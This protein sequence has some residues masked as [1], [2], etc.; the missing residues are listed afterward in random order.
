[1]GRDQR[2]WNL[3]LTMPLFPT[4]P[5]PLSKTYAKVK[6]CAAWP[7]YAKAVR[8]AAEAEIARLTQLLSGSQPP[9]PPPPPPVVTHADEFFDALGH[10][11]WRENGVAFRDGVATPSAEVVRIAP[12]NG[13]ARQTNQQGNS[14]D[15][16]EAVK[17]WVRVEVAEPL[18]PPVV[19][20]PTV[21]PTAG[22]ALYGPH[23]M[24]C[25]QENEE[26]QAI[27]FAK[28]VGQTFMFA[29]SDPP[30][31]NAFHGEGDMYA[32]RMTKFLNAA[33]AEGMPVVPQMQ[34]SSPE[35]VADAFVRFLDHPAVL[36]HNGKPVFAFWNWKPPTDQAVALARQRYG[37]P[38]EV[39]TSFDWWELMQPLHDDQA[40]WDQLAAL[41]RDHP[42]ID[43][44]LNFVVGGNFVHSD[45]RKADK[46][47]QQNTNMVNACRAAGKTAIPGFAVRY[48]THIMSDADQA[49]V[50]DN[51]VQLKPEFVT[52]TSANDWGES[53]INREE[54]RHFHALIQ[55]RLAPLLT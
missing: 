8:T 17:Q 29:F 20:P 1:M 21:P 22:R 2:R 48:Q 44:V 13:V 5:P 3:G 4:E 16:S 30:F 35:A 55:S 37:K 9:P 31:S 49:R 41:F 45:P 7:T 25:W 33:A 36:R 27:R 24:L 54:D 34:P 11:W 50:M 47:I 18:P 38:V 6:Q 40:N 14:W 32:R 42:Q 23:H 52:L 10:V 51:I 12:V 39:W 15:W 28:S 19:T 43:G 53:G 26:V 46:I